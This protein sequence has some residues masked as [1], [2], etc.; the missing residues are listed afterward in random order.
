[1]KD[2]T[3]RDARKIEFGSTLSN[4]RHAGRHFDYLIANPPYGM[5]WKRDKAA[6]KAEHERGAAGRFGPGLPRISDAQTLF[7]LHMLAR[8][9]APSE[10]GTRDSAESGKDPVSLT[11]AIAFL[12]ESLVAHHPNPCGFSLG[13]GGSESALGHES[14]QAYT[15]RVVGPGL[16]T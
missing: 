10:G 8:A 14:N 15:I 13:G 12:G 11:P 5:D 3:G 7:L 16:K 9:K 2:P 6:V 4:D 1:M